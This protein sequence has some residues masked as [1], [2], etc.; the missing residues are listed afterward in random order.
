MP[1]CCALVLLI[2]CAWS[3]RHV[4]FPAVPETQMRAVLIDSVVVDGAGTPPAPGSGLNGPVVFVAEPEASHGPASDLQFDWRGNP[5]LRHPARSR[6]FGRHSFRRAS[7]VTGEAAVHCDGGDGG[8]GGGCGAEQQLQA[9]GIRR[10]VRRLSAA[11]PTPTSVVLVQMPG[12]GAERAAHGG[13]AAGSGPLGAAVPS[14][15]GAPTSP[16]VQQQQQQLQQQQEQRRRRRSSREEWSHPGE[17]REFASFSSPSTNAMHRDAA[18]SAGAHAAAAAHSNAPWSPVPGHSSSSTHTT[19]AGRTIPLEGFT[20]GVERL[21]TTYALPSRALV[22]GATLSPR[23]TANAAQLVEVVEVLQPP[24]RVSPAREEH[25]WHG[26]AHNG[27]EGGWYAASP[28]GTVTAGGAAAGMR[29]GRAAS[30]PVQQNV[31]AQTAG[32]RALRHFASDR[33][34]VVGTKADVKEH[35]ECSGLAAIGETG[36]STRVGPG[37]FARVAA[38]AAEAA[39]VGGPV[40]LVPALAT[41]RHQ[42]VVLAAVTAATTAAASAGVHGSSMTPTPDGDETVVTPQ[43]HAGTPRAAFGASVSGAGVDSD[44]DADALEV[45]GRHHGGHVEEG[46]AAAVRHHVGHMEER[47]LRAQAVARL[48]H[49]WAEGKPATPPPVRRAAGALATGS[50]RLSPRS[51]SARDRPVGHGTGEGEGMQQ[52][53]EEEEGRS[54]EPGV[55][56]GSGPWVRGSSSSSGQGD[57]ADVERPLQQSAASEAGQYAEASHVK[58][59]PA[60]GMPRAGSLA[61]EML[62]RMGMGGRRANSFR[63]PRAETPSATPR[64]LAAMGLG[65]GRRDI[66][67]PADM[68]APTPAAASSAAAGGAGPPAPEPLQ[69]SLPSTPLAT[70]SSTSAAAAPPPLSTSEPLPAT[71]QPD[72]PSGPASSTP[73][74]PHSEDPVQ[75]APP[76]TPRSTPAAASAAATAPPTSAYTNAMAGR[77]AS[78]PGSELSSLPPSISASQECVGAPDGAPGA[79]LQRQSPA[80]HRL[81]PQTAAV[82]LTGVPTGLQAHAHAAELWGGQGRGERSVYEAERGR[83]QAGAAAVESEHVEGGT[84]GAASRPY[85]TAVGQSGEGPAGLV[86]EPLGT[87]RVLG[88]G[89]RES[90]VGGRSL[91]TPWSVERAGALGEEVGEARGAETPGAADEGGLGLGEGEGNAPVGKRKVNGHRTNRVY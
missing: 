7:S 87:R 15:W 41:S 25:Q 19:G 63:S 60:V 54:T 9:S 80:G 68:P 16:L 75:Q 10:G 49:G 58:L 85:T 78:R 31:V 12:A 53:Q 59:T 3:T 61:D 57:G 23:S 90:S 39:V 5:T 22:M 14:A 72:A 11:S 36:R 26:F 74:T 2:A 46:V 35:E 4:T 18:P 13:N 86:G 51:P 91:R 88:G 28:P 38:V 50:W 67:S 81:T 8:A 48:R 43:L 66:A 77:H 84:T 6:S 56:V 44:A 24:R 17:T 64:T 45:A 1:Y 82:G 71:H 76:H 32:G 69:Q 29:P 40:G 73:S 47:R 70:S 20:R 89:R 52:E 83:E 34:P 79:A 27:H 37:A 65:S 33:A 55:G 21:H 62:E 30:L 42:I